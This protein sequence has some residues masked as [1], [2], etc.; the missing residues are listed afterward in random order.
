MLG[1]ARKV[2]ILPIRIGIYMADRKLGILCRLVA[3]ECLGED[4]VD[5]PERMPAD[6]WK[7]PLTEKEFARRMHRIYTELNIV[8][9]S[10][11]DKGLVTTRCA[12]N[13]RRCFSPDFSESCY[14]MWR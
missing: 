1:S 4:E 9:N 2:N 14:N 5:P 3:K 7:R 13:R 12:I 11:R 10:R 6:V 8:W